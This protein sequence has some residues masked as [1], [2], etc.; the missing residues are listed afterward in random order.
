M[1]SLRAAR[2][3]EQAAFESIGHRT[4][5]STSGY[6]ASIRSAS[7]LITPLVDAAILT[8]VRWEVADVAVD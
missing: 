2:R 8:D 1:P 4:G 3:L 6:K 7:Q 5:M